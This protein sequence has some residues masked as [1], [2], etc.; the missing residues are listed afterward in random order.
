M[1]RGKSSEPR[2]PG[3]Q[4]QGL[5]PGN[6]H[7]GGQFPKPERLGGF[8]PL[9]PLPPRLPS[10]ARRIRLACL[11][12]AAGVGREERLKLYP[13]LAWVRGADPHAFSTVKTPVGFS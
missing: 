8:H 5:C 6:P 1:S 12:R 3:S 13:L 10:L 11:L 4:T 7:A 9:A 2:S